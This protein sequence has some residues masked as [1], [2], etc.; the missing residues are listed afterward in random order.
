M[1]M[2]KNPREQ[3][4]QFSADFLERLRA[5]KQSVAK[6]CCVRSLEKVQE[7]FSDECTVMTDPGQYNSFLDHLKWRLDKAYSS[8]KDNSCCCNALDDVWY[9]VLDAIRE[10]KFEPF[11]C[12][13]CNKILENRYR[14][15]CDGCDKPG[16]LRCDFER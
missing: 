1:V 3:M 14:D 13:A 5:Q 15:Y 6:A 12:K 16:R 11:L 2:V 10:T 7:F 9:A 8:N 4:E